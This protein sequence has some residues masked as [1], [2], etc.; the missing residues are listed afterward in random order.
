MNDETARAVL[1]A[2]PLAVCAF[3]AAG[4]LTLVNAS[5]YALG[6]VDP[7]A[8]APGATVEQA[9]RVVAYRGLYGPGD[10]EEQVAAA[11]RMDRTRPSRRLTR[12]LKG[13]WFEIATI[14][15]P[16]GGFITCAR[17]VSALKQAEVE[18]RDRAER[19]EAVLGALGHGVA[20]HDPQ[21]RVVLHNAAYESL[22][23]AAPSM[24]ADH[25]ELPLLLARLREAGEI[26]DETAEADLL[27]ILTGAAR[28]AQRERPNGRI[29]RYGSTPLP[30]G[31]FL[32]EASDITALKRAEDEARR[33]AAQLDGALEA[34]P[35]GVCVYGPD[36]RL[37]MANRAYGLIMAG[38]EVTPG[39][40][41]AD[42]VRRRAEA[43]E[44]GPGDP[45]EIARIQ[46]GFPLNR[47]Q[48]R[49]RMRPDGTAI[50]VRTAP[51]PDGGHIS[52]V[53]DITAIYRAEEEARRR[54][55]ILEMMLE[56]TRHG[57]ML[58]GP[59]RRLV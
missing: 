36:R 19:L 22:I 8:L 35:H 26:P 12:S 13:R 34:L 57:I 3:D 6:D 43:G 50:D 4:R 55:T 41:M 10:P 20:L 27:A 54:T 38:A 11:L 47:P 52:V 16:T 39:E 33:R 49:Q 7:S 9:I 40:H 48:A 29:I 14:P 28:R 15:L 31:G 46:L 37:V 30:D 32:V 24:L 2:L 17:E 58:F 18:A 1:D 51:L 59:D 25:P 21:R 53:T 44:Y 45:E 23:G 5:F 42:I 56:T